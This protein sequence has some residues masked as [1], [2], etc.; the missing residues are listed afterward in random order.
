MD[1]RP[2]GSAFALDLGARKLYSSLDWM[3]VEENLANALWHSRLANSS[4][5]RR[6][7]PSTND[8]LLLAATTVYTTRAP[9]VAATD[10][11]E[12]ATTCQDQCHG[13]TTKMLPDCCE[14]GDGKTE[15]G[16]EVV[17]AN[18]K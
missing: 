16:G 14:G 6:R 11:D 9:E 3:S 13:R 12:A 10:D 18:V 4:G 17:A 7:Y 8:L 2:F 5:E 1:A 15:G